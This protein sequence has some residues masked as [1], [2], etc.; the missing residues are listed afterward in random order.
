MKSF[1]CAEP[2][3]RCLVE[4]TNKE[5][6]LI[7]ASDGWDKVSNE[8]V[9][10]IARNC[11]NGCAAAMFSDS[12]PGSSATDAAALLAKLAVARGSMDNISVVV[13]KLRRLKTRAA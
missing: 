7:L 2:E 11:L 8:V 3:V 5:E 12:V 4:R 9:C 6:F 13:V 1:V 10:K